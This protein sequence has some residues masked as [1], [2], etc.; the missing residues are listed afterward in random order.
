MHTSEH[1]R[2]FRVSAEQLPRAHLIRIEGSISMDVADEMH[3]R[4]DALAGEGAGGIVVDM[5]G[6]EFLCSCA[7]GALIS[8]QNKYRAERGVLR[9]AGLREPVREIFETAR[10]DQLFAIYPTVPEAVDGNGG[11]PARG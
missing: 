8:V 10:L 7:L 2:E 11:V 3:E 5:S 1:Q 6:V 4:L 9:L